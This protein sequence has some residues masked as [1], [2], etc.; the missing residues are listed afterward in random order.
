LQILIIG[1]ILLVRS[2]ST[3]GGVMQK[4]LKYILG[5]IMV[6]CFT[7][8]AARAASSET[9][10]DQQRRQ[11]I[12]SQLQARGIKDR[13]VLEAVA[14]V[15]RHLFVPASYRHL[16]YG[17]F[18]L[19]IGEGQTISQ[20]YIVAL[21]S[22][23]LALT[24]QERILEIGTGSG[25]QAAILG[26]LAK[27][28]YTIEIIDFL[29]RQAEGLLKTLG[30]KNVKV[31]AGDGFLGWPEVAPFDGIIV[32]AAPEEIPAP[33]LAQLAEGGRLVIPVGGFWQE[34]KLVQK[35]QGKIKESSIA[36]VRFVPLLRKKAPQ[37]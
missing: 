31:K 4:Y 17:D 10:F 8:P 25:Y 7:P 29:A 24:G 21:M 33:L 20:P 14:K 23:L 19:P 6:L 16:S 18:P 22:E 35:V 30:Y 5:L 12:E 11:M 26:E 32:T 34:L 1:Y 28:V 36:P 9:A 3:R 27:E 13:R 37:P 2:Q 15:K